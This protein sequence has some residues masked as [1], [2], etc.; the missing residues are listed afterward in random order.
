V[1]GS[2]HVSS[3]VVV[4]RGAL[5]LSCD[6]LSGEPPRGPAGLFIPGCLAPPQVV[7]ASLG[8]PVY[9]RSMPCSSLSL[10][11][12]TSWRVLECLGLS[13]RVAKWEMMAM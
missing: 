12:C 8:L 7:W 3:Y 1:F 11:L 2:L 13:L 4:R 9:L 5:K 10:G 6:A